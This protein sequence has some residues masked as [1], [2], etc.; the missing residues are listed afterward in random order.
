M[1]VDDIM[2]SDPGLAAID[3][4]VPARSQAEPSQSSKRLDQSDIV[5]WVV[6]HASNRNAVFGQDQ[7]KISTARALT[8]FKRPAQ[9]IDRLFEQVASSEMLTQLGSPDGQPLYTSTELR[10]AEENIV[11]H[12]SNLSAEES[13]GVPG[14]IVDTV[15]DRGSFTPELRGALHYLSRPNRAATMVGVAGSAKTSVLGALNEAVDRFNVEALAAEQIKLVAFAPTNRA[16]Q[17]L[18]QKGLRDVATTFKAKDRTIGKN[19]I[20]VIDEMSMVKTQEIAQLIH[21][22]ASANS[23]QPTER[24]KLICVGDD[25][26]LPPVGPGDLLPTIMRQAGCYELVQPLRQLDEASRLETEKLGRDIR[27]DARSAVGNYLTALQKRGHVRFVSAGSSGAN[28][29]ASDQIIDRMLEQMNGV[30]DQYPVD[31]RLVMAHSN[32]SVNRA[33]IALH[34]RFVDKSGLQNQQISVWSSVM[35]G[36]NSEFGIDDGSSRQ[37]QQ[38]INLALGDRILFSENR[39]QADIRN[40]TFATVVGLRSAELSGDENGTHAAVRISARLDGSS[41]IVTWTDSEFTGFTYGYAATIHKSQGA[42]VDHAILICDGALSDKLTYVGLTRHRG[43]LDVIA[44]PLVANNV[45]ALSAKLTQQIAPNN[46]IQFPVSEHPARQERS[47]ISNEQ[48]LG[49][50]DRMEISPTTPRS[51]PATQES[52][53][54]EKQFLGPSTA[55][56]EMLEVAPLYPRATDLEVSQA[57]AITTEEQM[58]PEF[59]RPGLP[60]NASAHGRHQAWIATETKPQIAVEKRKR[61]ATNEEIEPCKKMARHSISSAEAV[62]D[63]IPLFERLN[64]AGS[65]ANGIQP[66]YAGLDHDTS[67]AGS[68]FGATVHQQDVQKS[69]WESSSADTLSK[70][71]EK[72]S[73]EDSG[74]KILPSNHQELEDVDVVGNERHFSQTSIVE[75]LRGGDYKK[76]V[77]TLVAAD[78]LVESADPGSALEAMASA[79][80]EDIKADPGKVRALYANRRVDVD[81]LAKKIED[82]GLESGRLTGDPFTFKTFN[83][84]VRFRVGDRLSITH[85]FSNVFAGEAGRVEEI[86]GK[87]IT[88]TLDGNGGR[89][90]FVANTGKHGDTGVK[91]YKIEGPD[92]IIGSGGAIKNHNNGWRVDQVYLLHNSIH[93]ANANGALL[94]KADERTK[95][96]TTQK[97]MPCKD[98]LA[99]QLSTPGSDLYR[100]Q[101]PSLP[102]Y[103]AALDRIA[104]RQEVL[105]ARGAAKPIVQTK[106]LELQRSSEPSHTEL[107]NSLKSFQLPRAQ[108]SIANETSIIRLSDRTKANRWKTTEPYVVAREEQ[109]TTGSEARG[110]RS[111]LPKENNKALQEILPKV[112]NDTE[113][114]TRNFDERVRVRGDSRGI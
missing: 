96:F 107:K 76:L 93:G 11:R 29:R 61:G 92:T 34:Q 45:Q 60:A 103:T 38:R 73:T 111:G 49:P 28:V 102:D 5:E 46:S 90:T 20:V 26:Q 14:T 91:G 87:F 70:F 52:S 32:R 99:P 42:T 6:N 47:S 56:V 43:R 84:E 80:E 66:I 97:Y 55:D 75:A 19:T 27:N 48:L 65:V 101:F 69:D 16:A 104:K 58:R 8:R 67:T 1:P 106:T 30:C 53:V 113:R 63:I 77:E 51:F 37:V 57:S 9:E 25:R 108:A 33:N 81:A 95:L 94:S 83:K 62:E 64:L 105:V 112:A 36:G 68:Q 31:D 98:I 44:S 21:K 7:L 3:T 114:L 50:V 2:M 88:F 74:Q 35:D 15:A 10:N 39:L 109:R 78:S 86:K 18:R 110:A 79:Y 23:Y 72:R 89:K 4:S 13:F 54:G 40:G 100:R 85:S 59:Y 24:P 22:I 12:V 82:R 41:R 17:E 71:S